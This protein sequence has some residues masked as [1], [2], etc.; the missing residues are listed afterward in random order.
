MSE[1]ESS[2]GVS[3]AALLIVGAAVK[4]ATTALVSKYIDTVVS[5]FL[6][7]VN[8]RAARAKIESGLRTYLRGLE[9]RTRCIPTIAIQSGSFLLEE[10][11]Q[12]LTL[13]SASDGCEFLVAQFPRDL[14]TEAR[15]VA[16]TDDAGMGKSTLAKFIARRAIEES[17]QIPLFVELRRIREGAKIVESI[18]AELG[19]R[20]PITAAEV[21]ALMES[22]NFLFILDGFDEVSESLRAGVIDQINQLVNAFP[23]CY[24]VLTSRKEFGV[25]AFP[26]YSQFEIVKL[27]REQAFDLIKRYD[28]TGKLSARLIEKIQLAGVDEFLGNPLLVTLLY[29]AFD[30]RPTIPPK[31][32]SF[33]RQVYDA[34]FYDH[35]LSKGD[36]FE[37][38][39]A[40]GLDVDDL[41]KLLRSFGFVTFKRGRVSFSAEELPGLLQEAIARCCLK[42]DAHEVKKDLTRAVPVVSRDGLEY[43]WS[44]KSF[45]EYFAAFHILQ[46]LPT[47]RDEVV[48]QLFF[49]DEVLRYS[50]LLRFVSE[51]DVSLVREV[52]AGALLQNLP[53][54]KTGGFESVG[55]LVADAIYIGALEEKSLEPS[56]FLALDEA[57]RGA[58]GISIKIEGCRYLVNRN[59]RYGVVSMLRPDGLRLLALSLIDP[60]LFSGWERVDE[61][62]SLRRLRREFGRKLVRFDEQFVCDA[63]PEVLAAAVSVAKVPTPSIQALELVERAR[64]ARSRAADLSFLESF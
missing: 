46:D 12:P 54:S 52:C 62:G 56:L 45:Q 36:G 26:A 32:S 57:V 64:H 2:M 1:S 33:F 27:S 63:A 7:G 34:L 28:R 37:R 17:K 21:V 18:A 31:R 15:C 6:K 10:V 55:L 14:F 5:P 47:T 39:K 51:V 48:R 4:G 50:E 20:E 60:G 13:R 41:H 44:H 40:S 53:R 23:F 3:S 43:K 49:R 42:A 19:G 38:E 59:E 9:L 22:G 11:Y 25:N 61:V 24:F 30:Y 8:A 35:D 58:F 29:K 16:I